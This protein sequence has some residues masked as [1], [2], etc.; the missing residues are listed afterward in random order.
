MNNLTCRGA[1][2]CGGQTCCSF[3]C[4]ELVIGGSWTNLAVLDHVW[5]DSTAMAV[6][7]QLVLIERRFEERRN[8]IIKVQERLL[9]RAYGLD[10][11]RATFLF[12]ER[13]Q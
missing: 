8:R 12:S 4:N 1:D 9:E 13:A 6:V 7:P 2:W 5:S 11:M 3:A 10:A